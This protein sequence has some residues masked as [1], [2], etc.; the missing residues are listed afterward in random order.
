MT[1]PLC[2][3]HEVK[4]IYIYIQIMFYTKLKEILKYEMSLKFINNGIFFL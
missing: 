3:I 4:Y 2:Q 1:I